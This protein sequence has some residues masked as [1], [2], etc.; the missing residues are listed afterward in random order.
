MRNS[1]ELM[2][3]T[4]KAHHGADDRLEEKSL[5][6]A[7]KKTFLSAMETQPVGISFIYVSLAS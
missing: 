6:R 1:T 4:N 5:S 3:A 7:K 2:M